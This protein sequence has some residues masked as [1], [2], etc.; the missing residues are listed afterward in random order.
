M[1]LYE[2]VTEETINGK[3]I[4]GNELYSDIDLAVKRY[5]EIR[6]NVDSAQLYRYREKDGKFV[7]EGCPYN[8]KN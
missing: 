4:R 5:Y 3:L 2:L 8:F 7:M 6:F 1:L